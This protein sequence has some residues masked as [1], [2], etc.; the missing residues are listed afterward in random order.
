MCN[1]FDSLEY[2]LQFRRPGASWCTGQS[3]VLDRHTPLYSHDPEYR[4]ND[5]YG[6]SSI[7]LSDGM[8]DSGGGIGTEVHIVT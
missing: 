7:L 1:R 4:N 5:F 6:A 2:I 3:C 8:L